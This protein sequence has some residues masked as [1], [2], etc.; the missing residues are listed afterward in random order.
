MNA[1]QYKPGLHRIALLTAAATLPL[2]MMGGEV[3]S[4]QAGLSVPDWPNSYGYNMFLFPPRLWVGGIL[5]EHVHRL[6]GSVVGLLSILLC[7]WAFKSGAPSRQRKL[8]LVVLAAVIFQ[9]ILGGLRVDLVDLALAVIH[10][11]F[12]Q[13]FFCL[14]ALM[15]ALS[16]RWWAEAPDLSSGPESRHGRRL[17]VAG[18]LTVLVV[19]NQLIVGAVMRH[20][21]AGLAVPD[22]PLVYHRFLPPT[23]DDQLQQINH[24]RAWQ[25]NLPPVTLDQIWLH[26]AHRVGALVV[27][28]FILALVA[29][30]LL[31]HRGKVG[32][33]GLAVVLLLLLLLQLV[34]GLT[35]V[36]YR[37]PADLA[38]AHVAVGALVL[39]TS[40][41]LTARAVRL[42]WPRPPA[43]EVS[44]RPAVLRPV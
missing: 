27:S 25:L 20:E 10:G 35:T 12:A 41:V 22:I 4:R 6:A 29:H 14:V 32:L 38:S 21:G 9:G 37:R 30:I 31:F 13:A 17:V 40:F 18:M 34:L 15:A 43:D 28:L 8:A 5:Y 11:C 39:V 44:V 7:V 33:T 42:Y 36:Y 2:I 23:T 19:Y 16:S 26:Y 3:T 24:L 1:S